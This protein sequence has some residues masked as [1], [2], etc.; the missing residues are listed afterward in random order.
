MK[1]AVA[2]SISALSLLLT[3]AFSGCLCD[4]DYC[5]MPDFFHPGHISEQQERMKQF[6]PYSRSDIGPRIGGERPQGADRET[7]VPKQLYEYQPR[8]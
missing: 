4:P 6:D 8:R 1:T 3:V 2:F 7:P 5:R